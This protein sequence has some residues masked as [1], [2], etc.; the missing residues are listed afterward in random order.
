MVRIIIKTNGEVTNFANFESM[1]ALN[2]W[3]SPL[4]ESKE[5]RFEDELVPAVLDMEGNVL[6]ESYV[7]PM[8]HTKEIIENWV[9]QNKINYEAR[10]YLNETD[11]YVIRLNET[12]TPIPAEVVQLRAEARAKV[13]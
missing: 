6:V 9:N 1:E 5:F 11:W 7:I 2:Q 4:I 3:L 8:K 12:G 13:Q 10:K